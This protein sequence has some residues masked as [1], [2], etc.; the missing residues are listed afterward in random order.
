MLDPMIQLGIK[1]G[2]LTDRGPLLDSIRQ[3][4]PALFERV[5]AEPD[6]EARR[7][8]MAELNRVLS[9]QNME[10]LGGWQLTQDAERNPDKWASYRDA[11]NSVQSLRLSENL[12]LP[13]AM[14][15]YL[16]R[17]STGGQSSPQ[18]T[19]SQPAPPA[20]LDIWQQYATNTGLS[21]PQPQQQYSAPPQAMPLQAAQ[22]QASPTPPAQMSLGQVQ[23]QSGSQSTSGTSAY[24]GQRYQQQSLGGLNWQQPQQRQGQQQAAPLQTGQQGGGLGMGGRYGQRRQQGL[25]MLG[26]QLIA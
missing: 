17:S 2:Y 24:P 15:L 3:S 23:P 20:L 14:G 4:L 1:S 13:E 8:K 9:A 18:A 11:Q 7:S 19:A 21:V 5:S 10:Q 25:G 22:Q 12:G 6:S 26:Q 16:A